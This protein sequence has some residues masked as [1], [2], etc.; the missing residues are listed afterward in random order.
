MSHVFNIP[1]D[2]E[3]IS[4]HLLLAI[5]LERVESLVWGLDFDL[6][7]SLVTGLVE[8]DHSGF[9]LALFLGDIDF[10]GE[11]GGLLPT[12]SLE[13]ST[14]GDLLLVTGLE[15]VPNFVG[16][17]GALAL[18]ILTNFDHFVIK[19]QYFILVQYYQL[20]VQSVFLSG[21]FFRETT[22][23]TTL[24]GFANHAYLARK[25]TTD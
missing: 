22:L 20:H 19:N 15:R 13:S 23:L 10:L 7:E 21:F 12:G 4:S 3:F 14:L 5:L 2:K 9:G 18:F 1:I 6:C 8:E 11:S 25:D 24:L 16:D 17:L